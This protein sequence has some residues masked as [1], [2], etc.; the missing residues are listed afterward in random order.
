MLE[1]F[2]SLVPD[3]IRQAVDALKTASPV[4]L[5]VAGAAL[6]FFSGAVKWVAKWVGVGL[7]VYG[8]LTLL[9]YL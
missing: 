5:I 1:M 4:I 3:F 9:G 6:F 7:I 8:L 2:A